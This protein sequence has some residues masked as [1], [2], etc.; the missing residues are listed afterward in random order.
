VAL[1]GE[2][3]AVLV[4]ASVDA[5]DAGFY[6]LEIS[7]SGSATT[8]NVAAVTIDGGD[9]RLA[10][11]STRGVIRAGGTLTPGF[12]LSGAG[13]KRLLVRAVGPTLGDFGVSGTLDDPTLALVPFGGAAAVET[14]DDWSDAANVV[15]LTAAGSAVGA[16]GLG[17]G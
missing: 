13:S 14:N 4:L 8:S 15:E 11:L 17:A 2:T 1:A 9:S 16:F 6:Y 10:N 7:D 3:T 12:A 5:S